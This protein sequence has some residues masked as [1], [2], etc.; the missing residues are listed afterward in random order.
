MLLK[1]DRPRAGLGVSVS[2]LSSTDSFLRAPYYSPR[3]GHSDRKGLFSANSMPSIG[4]G[5]FSADKADARI[6]IGQ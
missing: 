4:Q 5:T 6:Q 2:P 3:C 1:Q